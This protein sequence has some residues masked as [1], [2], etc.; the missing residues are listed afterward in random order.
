M[1]ELLHLAGV[2]LRRHEGADYPVQ[3]PDFEPYAHQQEL[4]D[5][6][7]SRDKFL[8]VNDSPTGGGKTM[9]W[10]APV[11]ESGD[12][13]LA[14]YPTNALIQDQEENLKRELAEHFPRRE[15]NTNVL[16]VTADALRT[17]Y[18]EEFPDADTNGERLRYLLR[19]RLRRSDG[20]V[21]V[22]TNPDIF[23]MMRRN[24]YG[25]PGDPGARI[26]GLNEFETIVADE[27]HRADR[28][29]QNTLLFLLDEMYDLDSYRCALSRIVL[30]S[31]TPTERL[32]QRFETAM[33]APYRRV[34]GLRT[35]TEQRDF[36]DI[37]ADGW[38]AVMPPVD[39]DVRSA[40]T[41]ATADE[42]LGD[43]WEETRAF[44]ARE[45]KTVFILDGIHEVDR[46]YHRLDAALDERNVVRIDGFH[47]GDLESKL[48]DFDVLVSNSA[49]EVGIDF[50]VDR[51]VFSGHNRSSFVQRLGRLRT[52]S[53]PQD[54]RCYVPAA[55]AAELGELSEESRISR[56]EL[57]DFLENA[58]D[59]PY[60]VQSFDWR[61]SAAEAYHHVRK[62]ARDSVSEAHEEVVERGWER[63]TRHFGSQEHSVTRTD[64]ERYVDVI[65]SA[66]ERTLEWYR[67]GS[68]QV[69]VYDRTPDATEAI[70]SY[71]LF[72]LLRYGDVEF[73]PRDE[74]EHL[75]PDEHQSDISHAAPFVVGYCTYD[76]TIETDEDG[77][78]RDVS[79]EATADVF[80]WL[81][82]DDGKHQRTRE[83]RDLQ[84]ISIDVNVDDGAKRI[85]SL[86]HLRDGL[87]DDL[88]L[89]CYAV[90]DSPGKAKSRYPLG[91]FFF[92]YGLQVAEDRMSA[93][94]GVDALY[95]HCIVQDE[96]DPGG[97]EEL[98]IDI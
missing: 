43:D 21:I 73:F 70:K 34:T 16:T 5:L 19:S 17:D 49:V 62:R 32:E 48:R 30:L 15:D 23:V 53:E 47:R 84:E 52:E 86:E 65:D 27:F 64:I 9:S 67:G 82:S 57:E 59:D 11:I 40:S 98:G 60:D 38:S 1:S 76:G 7:Q 41:F 96:Y 58:Y 14:V 88:G 71:N 18:A 44:A 92:L 95:L 93:A 74:F 89:L 85:D 69:L 75:V 46:V 61:Y 79:L 24:L 6:F 39:L 2:E 90:D 91:S 20:Q 13:A 29:E 97:L 63:I 35:E 22:L 81:R 72:Y 26:R 51:L 25:R 8:A 36:E 10:L 28:K 94:L 37:P 54:A 66:V 50:T 68:L 45:G 87:K 78:G 12:N 4:L 56:R 42:L 31:A 83:P 3:S 33:S 80:T 77:Y 55:V